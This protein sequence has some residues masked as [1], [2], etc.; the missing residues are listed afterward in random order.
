M[1]IYYLIYFIN[2][3]SFTF[4]GVDDSKPT[5]KYP[6][7]STPKLFTGPPNSAKYGLIPVVLSGRESG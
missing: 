3:D 5:I 1:F 6:L 4:S 2:T 7:M